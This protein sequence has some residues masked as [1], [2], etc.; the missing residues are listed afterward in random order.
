VRSVDARP[1]AVSSVLI[2][3]CRPAMTSH[4]QLHPSAIPRA[5][6]SRAR[7]FILAAHHSQSVFG[8]PSARHNQRA[9]STPAR[10]NPHRACYKREGALARCDVVGQQRARLSKR[11]P[12]WPAALHKSGDGGH[13]DSLCSHRGIVLGVGGSN[14]SERATKKRSVPDT[15]VTV[16]T[17]ERSRPGARAFVPFSDF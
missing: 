15:W 9:S 16:Y 11:R 7:P 5:P 1:R 4:I 14:S 8:A 12:Y 2:A 3:G 17:G 6:Q 13:P 10:P